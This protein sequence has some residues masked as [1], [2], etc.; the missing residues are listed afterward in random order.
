MTTANTS[1]DRELLE[2][3][4]HAPQLITSLIQKLDK[5][6]MQK[7]QSNPHDIVV[8][9]IPPLVQKARTLRT[10]FQAVNGGSF[11]SAQRDM[12]D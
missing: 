8:S 12:I 1:Q 2:L 10:N 9:M 5:L 4:P 11:G 3:S 6:Y 7:S